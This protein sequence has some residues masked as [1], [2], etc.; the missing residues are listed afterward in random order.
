LTFSPGD[1]ALAQAIARMRHPR[2]E[3]VFG[4]FPEA[5]AATERAEMILT[6]DGGMTHV[7]SYYGVPAVVLFTSG[8]LAKWR[9]L[10]FGSRT[11]AASDLGCRP[12]AR[13]GQVPKCPNGYACKSIPLE[14]LAPGPPVRG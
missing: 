10:S 2:T 13:F 4:G 9:P 5:V 14:E 12:C 3:L 8:Q 6:V 7:A 1:Q 11:I